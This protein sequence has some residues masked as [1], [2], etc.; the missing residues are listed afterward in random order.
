MCVSKAVESELRSYV[1]EQRKVP[2]I[3]FMLIQY[4]DACLGL[5][6][7]TE[8]LQQG[9]IASWGPHMEN[10]AMQF[11]GNPDLQKIYIRE[12]VLWAQRFNEVMEQRPLQVMG[13]LQDL[14]RVSFSYD[15]QA[16][17]MAWGNYNV[18][19]ALGK[20]GVS[21]LVDSVKECVLEF[22]RSM[23]SVVESNLIWFG[24]R[25]STER[26]AAREVLAGVRDVVAWVG[27]AAGVAGVLWK[28]NRSLSRRRAADREVV[29][30]LKNSHGN[31]PV[32]LEVTSKAL[33]PYIRDPDKPVGSGVGR[34]S[35]WNGTVDAFRR[36]CWYNPKTD[37]V[38]TGY[39]DFQGTLGLFAGGVVADPESRWHRSKAKE[40]AKMDETDGL[41]L[42]MLVYVSASF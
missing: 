33:L 10:K 29:G 21:H 3:R 41:S 19:K 26:D 11:T 40:R 35:W 14:V 24:L 20:D 31:K 42:L 8:I 23:W 22:I 30:V 37:T 34:S 17:E 1:S 32:S 25:T 15:T 9:L 38:E 16:V 39:A 27:G 2:R 6:K 28:A 36:W 13:F 18:L 7:R 5:K 4:Q 12:G